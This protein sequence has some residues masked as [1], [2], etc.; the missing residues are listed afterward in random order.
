MA[1]AE[2]EPEAMRMQMKDWARSVRRTFWIEKSV[3]NSDSIF[4]SMR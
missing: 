4:A 3:G 2:E 1:G